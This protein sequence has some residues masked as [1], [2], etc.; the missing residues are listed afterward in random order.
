MCAVTTE[1]ISVG[2]L[3]KSAGIARCTDSQL[4]VEHTHT[5]CSNDRAYNMELNVFIYCIIV[6]T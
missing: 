2:L 1:T 3:R 4:I 5:S 6:D